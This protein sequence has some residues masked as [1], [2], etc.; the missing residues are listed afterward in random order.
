MLKFHCTNQIL[1]NMKKS[2]LLL[3][4]LL[5]IACGTQQSSKDTQE[6]T[7]T[8]INKEG[9]INTFVDGMEIGKV[10]VWESN[11]NKNKIVTVCQKNDK[12]MVLLSDG[13]Y[14]KI[15]TASG[16]EGWVMHGFVN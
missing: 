13:T 16:Q 7:Y 11:L 9:T 8:E 15:K 1:N 14:Y 2:A 4:L 6:S 12:V 3:V 5:F 10:N